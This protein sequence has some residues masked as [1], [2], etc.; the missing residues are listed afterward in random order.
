MAAYEIPGDLLYSREDEW[1]RKEDDRTSIGVTDYAQQQLGDIVFLELP[2][3]GTRVERGAPFG[4]I[5]SVKAVADLFAPISGEV[6]AVNANLEAH[7]EAVNEDC[8]GD[9]W[10][11]AIQAQEDSG[12]ESLLDAKGY[13]QHI[14]EREK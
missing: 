1:A 8:Y 2:E 4:V 10:I 7:P 6:V 5:E 14:E 11:L 13:L 9:G 12:F 3:I